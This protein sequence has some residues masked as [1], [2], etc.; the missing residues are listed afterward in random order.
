MAFFCLR[1]TQPNCF[2]NLL[3]PLMWILF[4]FFP[5]S[6]SDTTARSGKKSSNWHLSSFL[7]NVLQIT[8][9]NEK[10]YNY[11]YFKSLNLYTLSHGNSK[12]QQDGCG[13]LLHKPYIIQFESLFFFNLLH[14]PFFK[15]RSFFQTVFIY[16]KKRAAG[17]AF[18]VNILL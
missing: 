16:F 12:D 6:L 4:I 10:I 18:T 9:K 13:V 11:L 3:P 15:I 8:H 5:C 14:L 2:C 7:S 17:S 1:L